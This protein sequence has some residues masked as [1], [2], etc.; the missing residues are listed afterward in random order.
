MC[1]VENDIN[2]T[3][4]SWT[5]STDGYNAIHLNDNGMSASCFSQRTLTPAII[6][7][8]RVISLLWDTYNTQ[9][10]LFTAEHWARSS[11]GIFYGFKQLRVFICK[12]R[13]QRRSSRLCW[14]LLEVKHSPINTSSWSL[15]NSRIGIRP[16]T[17]KRVVA[18]LN[19]GAFL[20]FLWHYSVTKFIN[21]SF[22][23][24]RTV[25]RLAE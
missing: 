18:S 2:W 22:V 12:T 24:A 10:V 17:V 9:K 6:I 19:S 23:A 21:E 8:E 15:F 16:K 3:S 7:T 20:H 5:I 4:K 25:P 11:E 14:T 1:L 13:L